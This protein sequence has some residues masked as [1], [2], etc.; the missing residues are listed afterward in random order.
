MAKI[1]VIDDEPV[2]R[3][4]LSILLSQNGY[5]VVLAENGWKGL[6]LYRRENPDAILLDLR[7]PGLDGVTVLEEIRSVDLKQQVIV[8]TGDT[9]PETKRKVCAL[10]VTEFIQKGAPLHLL[11][12]VL[13]R[14]LNTRTPAS[15]IPTHR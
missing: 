6:E 9:N 13:R 11:T 3:K 1:L 10:G 5:D 2:V 4:L 14:H 15:A 8:L 12:D 7:M